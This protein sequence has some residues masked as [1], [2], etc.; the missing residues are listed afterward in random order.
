MAS[1]EQRTGFRFGWGSS[2]GDGD[3]SAERQPEEPQ[4]APDGSPNSPASG[5]GAT[6]ADSTTP[7]QAEQAWPTSD[8]R[9][10]AA[11]EPA[12]GSGA[13]GF[14]SE[15]MRAMQAAAEQAR[16]QIMDRFTDEART[17]VD[18]VRSRSGED[19]NELRRGAD[20][21][22]AAIREWSKAEIARIKSETDERIA[23]RRTELERQVDG[24][25][26][27]VEREIE[28]FQ[29]QVS[30][31]EQQMDGFFARLQQVA[32][33]STFA[34][35]AQGMPEPPKIEALGETARSEALAE[36]P[37]SAS[38][39]SGSSWAPRPQ[40]QPAISSAAAEQTMQ[41]GFST[42]EAA[43]SEETALSGGPSMATISDWSGGAL[44]PTPASAE[45]WSDDRAAPSLSSSGWSG[46][47]GA[48]SND[49]WGTGTSGGSASSG[50]SSDSPASTNQWSVPS[51]AP[52][53]AP[54]S[55]PART[56]WGSP[57]AEST[58]APARNDWGS[59]AAESTSA[60]ARNDWGSP[61]AESTSAPAPAPQTPEADRIVYGAPA[62][63]AAEAL[64]GSAPASAESNPRPAEQP[65]AQ[66][67]DDEGYTFSADARLAAL[68]IIRNTP[69]A[70]PEPAAASFT[71][72]TPAIEMPG[73]S[74]GPRSSDGPTPGPVESGFA[75][76][77]G[78]AFNSEAS[79]SE[80]P[81]ARLA[82]LVPSSELP[83]NGRTSGSPVPTQ[84][85]VTGLLSV[86]SIASFKRHLSRIPGVQ[87]VGVSSGPEG[88][89]IF[90]TTHEPG[91][92]LAAVIPT[93]P[94]FGA[95]VVNAA[96]GTIQV[97]AHDPEADA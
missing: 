13:S 35:V 2:K 45:G 46:G 27:L 19:L 74:S 95:E 73:P 61:A 54:R 39:T 41:D 25:G 76:I 86:A 17:H 6:G 28:R 81:A 3:K 23:G 92:A 68:G 70:S 24:H 38:M 57:A 88:E 18:G 90:K 72:P 20:A 10:I 37:L 69:P 63:L 53:T 84:V 91:V 75:S 48:A 15:L 4:A 5:H 62:S 12:P 36:A 33:P 67:A 49:S 56:D 14:L 22:V 32:D 97:A 1:T 52:Q 93:L 55:E 44:S 77:P 85:I 8:V 21:D 78:Q 47:S 87:S 65:A 60:P 59:P 16:K 34:A 29:A 80:S 83:A 89:F 96:E 58:S 51:E 9:G 40:S 71:S 42:A 50:W 11:S 26:A 31:F 82:G 79:S 7:P 66:D 64:S 94:G 43:A 30:A